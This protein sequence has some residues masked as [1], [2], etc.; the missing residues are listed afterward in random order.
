MLICLQLPNLQPQFE[1]QLWDPNPYIHSSTWHLHLDVSRAPHSESVSPWY[2][3]IHHSHTLTSPISLV[4]KTPIFTISVND[5]MIHTTTHSRKWK[6]ATTTALFSYTA[7]RWE[8]SAALQGYLSVQLSPL[9]YPQN[10]LV[11]LA[12]WNSQLCLLHLFTSVCV[13]SPC[14]VSRQEVEGNWAILGITFL[15]SL[16]LGINVLHGSWSHDIKL[17]NFFGL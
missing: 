15:I 14:A 6:S 12:S 16:I 4:F 17:Y 9:H 3:Y 10:I 2:C 5:T 13:Q 11:T 1:L 8:T 7:P